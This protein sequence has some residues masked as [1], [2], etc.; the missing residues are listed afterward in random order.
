M[1]LK[2]KAP[3]LLPSDKYYGSFDEADWAVAQ[4]AADVILKHGSNRGILGRPPEAQSHDPKLWKRREQQLQLGRRLA[5]AAVTIQCFVCL[6]AGVER[7]QLSSYGGR[8]QW[9]T[10]VKKPAVARQRLDSR[11]SCD[12]CD[13]GQ[14]WPPA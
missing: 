10:F 13:F 3:K 5:Q 11:F 9:P 7:D 6:R 1:C 12:K 14:G 2:L 8:S 4:G